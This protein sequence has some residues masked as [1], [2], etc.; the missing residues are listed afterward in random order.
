VSGVNNNNWITELIM[1]K[2]SRKRDKTSKKPSTS[3]KFKA[4]KFFFFFH[5][6]ERREYGFDKSLS[7]P[8]MSNCFGLFAVFVLKV[9]HFHDAR[10][11]RNSLK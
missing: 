10:C 7:S 6:R 8:E 1:L 3:F 11:F 9:G 2:S 5:C 4:A